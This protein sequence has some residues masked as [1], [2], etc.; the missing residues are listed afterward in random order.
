MVEMSLTYEGQ[1][2]CTAVHAP[3]KK[4][5]VTDAPTDNG[6]RG[7]NFAPSDLLAAALGSCMLTYIGKA[8]D[9]NGWDVTGT[10][11]VLQKEMVAD[12][13]RRVGRITID[14]YLNREFEDRDM[15]ILTNAVTT[16]PVKL[17]ISDQIE[18]PITFHQPEN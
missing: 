5:I 7:Q 2:R 8:G 14:I 4:K 6:G 13:L 16:C 9:K 17:S 11:I 12:P 15:R 1:Q 18:V 3:S 10:R